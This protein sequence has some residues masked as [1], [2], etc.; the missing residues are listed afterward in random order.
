MLKTTIYIDGQNFLYGVAASLKETGIISDKQEISSIDIPFLFS[1]ILQ[2][3]L[4]NLNDIRYYGVSKI[5]RQEAYGERMLEKSIH[6]A[7]NLR[8]LRNCLAKTGVKYIP[9]GQLRPR[10]VDKCKN[11]GFEDYKFQEKGVDVGLAVDIVRDV[12]SGQTNHVVL[13]SSDTDLV[14]AVR[15]AKDKGAKITY[16][17]FD[18]MIIRSLFALSNSTITIRRHEIVEAYTRLLK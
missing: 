15:V 11:C 2:E 4:K 17:S 1:N 16:I 14:P 6:F 10:N 5:K 9:C 7:E 18:K 8:K 12:M 13:A 3:P